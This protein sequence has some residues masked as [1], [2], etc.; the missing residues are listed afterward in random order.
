VRAD[1]AAARRGARVARSRQ[2]PCRPRRWR[3]KRRRRGRGCPRLRAAAVRA[4]PRSRT[5]F[6]ISVTARREQSRPWCASLSAKKPHACSIARTAHCRD[7]RHSEQSIVNTA[8]CS[9]GQSAQRR[10]RCSSR[11]QARRGEAAS[12]E[13]GGRLNDLPLAGDASGSAS[14]DAAYGA[15]VVSCRLNFSAHFLRFSAAEVQT[16]STTQS[17]F[18]DWCSVVYSQ[19]PRRTSFFIRPLF[20]TI[21]SSTELL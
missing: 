9:S 10:R 2:Y 7:A 15:R 1:G 5:T 8:P 19:L 20:K 21:L 14:C 18:D 12:G 17:P 11:R 4:R 13:S 6:R 16:T 3:A